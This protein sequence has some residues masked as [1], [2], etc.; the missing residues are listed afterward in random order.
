VTSGTATVTVNDTN[1]LQSWEG[2]GGA[3]NEAGWNYLLMLSQADRDRAIQLLFGTDGAHFTMGRIPMGA[4]DYALIRYTSDETANDTGLSSFSISRDTQYLVPYVKAAQAVNGSIRFWASPWTPPTWMKT[5]SGSVNGTSCARIGS[6]AYDGGCMA[7]NNTYL[8]SLAQYFVKWVQAYGQQGITIEVVA[9]QNEPNYAQ[10]YPSALWASPVFARFVGQN[11]G[12]ALASAGLSTKIM[13]GTMSNNGANKDPT[14]VSAVMGDTTARSYIKLIGMQWGMQSGVSGAKQYNLPIWQTEHK[15]GNY[16]W[17]GGYVSS[18]A[19][20]DQAYG[21]ETWGLIRDWIKAGVT[22]Y[23]AWNMVLDRVGKGND[24]TRDWAQNS[25]LVVDTS[26]RTLTLTPA[27][28]VFRHF[29]QYVHPGARVV[30]T[31]GG[32]AMAFKNTDGTIV[33]IMYNA[34]GAGTYIVQ[35]AGKKLQFS[36]PGNGWATVVSQ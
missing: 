35:I 18:A 25:L 24:T 22:A 9:P 26:A 10:G 12:P 30:G 4:S 33:A 34:G 11:L 14:V 8:A 13:L 36:M 21:V 2:F 6:T 20:N 32:D 27:Y 31:T 28:Y 1:V 3:F 17:M 15:C 23:S 29:S 5:N 16:P 7:D 19:P